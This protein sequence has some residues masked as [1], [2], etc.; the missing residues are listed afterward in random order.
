VIQ[1]S[2][3]RL[4]LASAS[5][6]RADLLARL[7]VPFDI[8]PVDIEEEFGR[9]SNPQIVARRLAREKAEAARLQDN[10]GTIVAADTIVSLDGEMLGKPK[11]A[12]EARMMLQSLRGRTHEVVTAVA[13]LPGGQR[14]ALVRHPVTRVTMRSYEDVEI[15]EAVARADLFDKAGSYAIQDELLRPV[16]A[17]QGC[18][19][20]VVGLP[21]WTAIELL[22]RAGFD[23]THVRPADLLPQCASC[24]LAR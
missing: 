24:P 6:R 23:V 7:G 8:R 21:L 22:S 20:N 14:S 16:E 18:Y 3:A 1:D 9:S 13:V 12:E 10:G 5:P 11:D 2:N 4:I 19:C 15:E 17:Y